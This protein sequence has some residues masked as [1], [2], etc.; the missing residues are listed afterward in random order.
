MVQ[1]TM[2]KLTKLMVLRK[3]P[4]MVIRK[5]IKVIKLIKIMATIKEAIV[6][7]VLI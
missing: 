1:P 7:M 5:I 6:C 2:K 3:K 4:T